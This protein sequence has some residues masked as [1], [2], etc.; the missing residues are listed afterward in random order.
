[1]SSVARGA[2]AAATACFALVLAAPAQA[3]SCSARLDAHGVY[4]A[5]ARPVVPRQAAAPVATSAA[6]GALTQSILTELARGAL[7]A[8]GSHATGHLL[9]SIGLKNATADQLDRMTRQIAELEERLVALGAS[10]D[11]LKRDHAQSAF[12]NL[13]TQALPIV[14]AIKHVKHEIKALDKIPTAAGK[15]AHGREIL[16][17]ICENL[18]D[19]Q[20]ELNER[21]VG[22]GTGADNIITS[23]SKLMKYST[24][25]WTE[26]NTQV[27]RQILQY[28][29]MLEA[30]LLELRVEWW[31]AT[32]KEPSYI[33]HQIEH[34]QRQV[35]NQL[36]L[37]KPGPGYRHWVD[38]KHPQVVWWP[39]RMSDAW[40]VWQKFRASELSPHLSRVNGDKDK[41]GLVSWAWKDVEAH[42]SGGGNRNYLW[43]LRRRWDY[44]YSDTLFSGAHGYRPPSPDEVTTLFRDA[45][46]NPL[47]WL[48][49]Q[50]ID[51]PLGAFAWNGGQLH[52]EVIWTS[53]VRTSFDLHTGRLRFNEWNA[54]PW[55]VIAVRNVPL[56]TYW[57]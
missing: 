26:H 23:S 47:A 45:S 17:Y 37:L 13:V 38:T 30:F 56:H 52:K 33:Q 22:T 57:Y 1:M 15:Q 49:A 40:G 48:R 35:D 24:R 10:I 32:G 16:E 44:L 29:T 4:A 42:Q 31:H 54:A 9:S 53:Q 51:W 36:S 18:L 39:L 19:K 27:L 12:T 14:S 3:A 7:R 55:G 50:G 5:G 28:Y 11:E 43:P 41:L 20:T 34:V 25:L 2:C 46:P 21:I 8:T 6:A